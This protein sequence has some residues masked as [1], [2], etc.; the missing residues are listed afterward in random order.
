MSTDLYDEFGNYIGGDLPDDEDNDID[1][2]EDIQIHRH[3]DDDEDT[4]YDHDESDITDTLH[5]L[6]SQHTT[7]ASDTAL[8]I[9]DSDQHHQH[10]QHTSIV[11]REDLDHYPEAH[12]V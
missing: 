12:Q 8:Q 3:H 10:Q 7:V 9:P 11:L 1:I 5:P 6:P 4:M 2:N